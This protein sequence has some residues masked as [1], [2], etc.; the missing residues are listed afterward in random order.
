M[1]ASDAQAAAARPPARASRWC[2][3]SAR[4]LL[5]LLL[6]LAAAPAWAGDATVVE[7]AGDAIVYRGHLDAQA[8]AR[9]AELLQ[10]GGVRWLRIT[11]GGGEVNL[12]MDLGELVRAHRLDVEVADY[13]ASS[14][15]NYVFPAGVRKRLPAGSLVVWHGSAIQQGVDDPASLDFADAERQLGRALTGAERAAAFESLRAYGQAARQRQ[16]AFFAAL[17]VDPRVTVFG[18]E[19][20][21]GCEW[22]LAPADMARFGI[23]AVQAAPGYGS[24]R[25]RGQAYPLLRLADHPAYAAAIDAARAAHPATE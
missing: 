1:N 23:T 20:G 12:G 19:V 6:C 7:R 13:C 25:P 8:N 18:Q 4:R 11:S 21:C 15:A 3:A 14:C 5:A 17:G 2:G 16:A 10:D 24:H 22:T 9:V